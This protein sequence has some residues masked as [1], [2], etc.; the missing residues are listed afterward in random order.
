[1]RYEE[2]LIQQE[3][4]A[5]FR[6]RYPQYAK[7]LFHPVNEGQRTTK[8]VNNRYGSKVVCTGGA[9]LKAEGM[10]KGVADLILLVPRNGYGALCLETKTATGKQEPEQKEWQ[11]AAEAAGNKY[12]VYR[13]AE[14][15]MQIIEDY[16]DGEP[17]NDPD[18]HNLS[19]L[20]EILRMV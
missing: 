3:F 16:L 15:G 19:T 13:S 12:V 8:V 4:V 18:A 5:R 17:V 1:M 7:V 20:Q 14:E 11:K 10:V 9:R 2:S 6:F